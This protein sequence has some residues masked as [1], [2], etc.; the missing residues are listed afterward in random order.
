MTDEEIQRQVKLAAARE[1]FRPLWEAK[2]PELARKF[3]AA[4]LPAEFLAWQFFL[5]GKGLKP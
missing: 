3:G 5:I 1:E 2:K 4:M